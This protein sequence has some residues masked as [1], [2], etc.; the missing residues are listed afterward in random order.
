MAHNCETVYR[1]GH[2]SDINLYIILSYA[3]GVHGHF[4]DQTCN[5]LL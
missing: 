2:F 3:N 1:F 4:H 5:V